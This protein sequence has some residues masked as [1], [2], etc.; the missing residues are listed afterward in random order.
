MATT[1]DTTSDYRGPI[2]TLASVVTIIAGL[3]LIASPLVLHEAST[4]L[5]VDS[6]V[7]GIAVVVLEIIRLVVRTRST[8]AL[9]WI[10]VALGLWTMGGPFFFGSLGDTSWSVIWPNVITGVVIAAFGAWSATGDRPRS[11]P[12]EPGLNS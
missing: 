6:I 3:W 4:A 10:T 9:P 5:M 11:Y 7:V 8:R 1:M 2:R 12:I